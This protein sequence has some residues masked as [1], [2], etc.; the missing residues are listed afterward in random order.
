GRKVA[1]TFPSA[2]SSSDFA[3]VDAEKTEYDTGLRPILLGDGRP[4]FARIN[5]IN[6]TPGA[7]PRALQIALNPV[8]VPTSMDAHQRQLMV[9]WSVVRT[10][11]TRRPSACRVCRRRLQ[12]R[13]RIP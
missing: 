11:H 5:A 1:W 3:F 2:R 9:R 7:R 13:P 8:K 6:L 10:P 4:L 12:G